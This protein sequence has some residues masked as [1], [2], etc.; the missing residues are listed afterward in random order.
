[1]R[2][3]WSTNCLYTFSFDSLAATWAAFACMAREEKS[4][5]PRHGTVARIA[6]KRFANNSVPRHT[7]THTY[8]TLPR[9]ARIDLLSQLRAEMMC[10]ECRD[11][12]ESF[13]MPHEY[14]IP[15]H[16]ARVL[17][18]LARQQTQNLAKI[19]HFLPSSDWHVCLELFSA[20][21]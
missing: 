3:K 4:V 5:H 11:A 17:R 8:T 1:M 9:V 12:Q 10:C 21:L 18:S 20:V 7:H 13:S 19:A 15:A 16:L 6:A 2:T 14:Y